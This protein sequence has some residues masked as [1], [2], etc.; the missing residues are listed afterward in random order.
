M[1]EDDCCDCDNDEVESL[2]KPEPDPHQRA[3]IQLLGRFLSNVDNFT[4]ITENKLANLFCLDRLIVVCLM[5]GK[6]FASASVNYRSWPQNHILEAAGSNNYVFP[7]VLTGVIFVL[8]LSSIFITFYSRG[9]HKVDRCCTL[10][11]MWEDLLWVKP[12]KYTSHMFWWTSLEQGRL[13]Q[14]SL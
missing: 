4:W 11:S 6:C 7:R 12:R 13:P 9:S 3:L 10:I 14:L 1:E 2:V 8:H 5:K